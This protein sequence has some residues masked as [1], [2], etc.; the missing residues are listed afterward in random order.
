[1]N[2]ATNAAALGAAGSIAANMVGNAGNRREQKRANQYNLEQWHRQNA[3]NNPKRQMERLQNAGL[4]PNLIYGTSPTSAVG[5]AGAVAPAKAADFSADN[6]LEHLSSYANFGVQQ[7]QTDNLRAQSEVI[8]QDAILKAA[9]TAS[10][11][12][13]TARSKFDLGLAQELKN[14]S[15]D[16]AKQ[17]LKQLEARTI[18]AEI[19]NEIKDR[20]KADVIKK[21]YYEAQNA[22]SVL[23]GSDLTNEL[24]KLEINL[25]KIGVQKSDNLFFRV[26]GQFMDSNLFNEYKQRVQKLQN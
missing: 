13:G 18:E 12:A 5:N 15:V 24:R 25:N 21:I 8:T 23:K 3:Y 9:Q 16:A 20:T 4:N 7:A 2:D 17:N 6:P 10:T 1:M 22:A 14:T 11:A 19:N 26:L